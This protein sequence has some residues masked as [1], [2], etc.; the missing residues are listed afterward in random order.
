MTTMSRMAEPDSVRSLPAIPR[1][2]EVEWGTARFCLNVLAGATGSDRLRCRCC[3][4]P[5]GWTGGR[6]RSIPS[7]ARGARGSCESSRGGSPPTSPQR[8]RPLG[9]TASRGGPCGAVRRRTMST[10]GVVRV[11]PAQ[12]L[13]RSSDRRLRT[14]SC[15][16]TRRRSA[17]PQ[18]SSRRARPAQPAILALGDV[19]RGEGCAELPGLEA[20]GPN[21]RPHRHRC[22]RPRQ[23]PRSSHASDRSVRSLPP[24]RE[25]ADV[26]CITSCCTGNEPDRIR[27]ESGALKNGAAEID[28][29][30][31]GFST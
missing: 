1:E 14:I 16:R 23:D 11:S 31:L 28:I 22:P 8:S 19:M 17:R 5:R 24:R 21:R 18:F 26:A 4:G 9:R 25:P 30:D 2:G 15:A 10:T 27:V 20:S 3:S 13:P 12:G 7:C 29:V 6:G